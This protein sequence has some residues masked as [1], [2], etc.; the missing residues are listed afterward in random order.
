ML[1][2]SGVGPCMPQSFPSRHP[3]NGDPP[4][5]SAII[6]ATLACIPGKTLASWGN[7][8]CAGWHCQPGVMAMIRSRLANRYAR[9]N[10]V[11]GATRNCV[12][13]GE[14]GT[15]NAACHTLLVVV[16]R[17]LFRRPF[18]V[19]R[20]PRPTLGVS[21]SRGGPA[22]QRRRQ[23]KASRRSG[24]WSGTPIRTGYRPGWTPAQ[25]S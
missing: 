15:K 5:V 21:P 4:P 3:H 13:P 25:V 24:K 12:C 10:V 9:A 17:L 20:L 11:A 2:P 8:S 16:S 19:F 23:A 6:H 7:L 14:T 1:T 18:R 22:R